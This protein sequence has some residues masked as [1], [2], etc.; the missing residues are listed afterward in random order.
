MRLRSP[1]A[2]SST[3]RTAPIRRP[4]ARAPIGAAPP[5]TLVRAGSERGDL[6]IGDAAVE[7]FMEPLPL[8]APTGGV[9]PAVVGDVGVAARDRQE[10]VA[11]AQADH[12]VGVAALHGQVAGAPE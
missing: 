10:R 4:G 7:S 12:Q 6:D 3:R 5:A 8:V 2:R 1:G 11:G 9:E